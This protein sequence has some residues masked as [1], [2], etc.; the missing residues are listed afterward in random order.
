MLSYAGF[1]YIPLFDLRC[2]AKSSVH[3][4]IQRSF[5]STLTSQGALDTNL[6]ESHTKCLPGHSEISYRFSWSAL[7][8]PAH[9]RVLPSLPTLHEQLQST[10]HT[11][12]MFSAAWQSWGPALK[13]ADGWQIYIYIHTCTHYHYKPWLNAD[14]GWLE[15]GPPLP[16][17]C[18]HQQ[19]CWAAKMDFGITNLSGWTVNETWL[20]YL[21]LPQ[22]G[23]NV[24]RI[25]TVASPVHHQPNLFIHMT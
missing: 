7:S 23:A 6:K 4:K 11:Q 8:L 16:P 21:Q 17:Y 25:N 9:L 2:M 24:S 13:A 14:F 20:L 19:A 5:T 15:K 3:S 18:N 10:A 1:S 12:F 22:T